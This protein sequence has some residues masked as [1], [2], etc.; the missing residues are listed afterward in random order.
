MVNM[1][2][3]FALLFQLIHICLIDCKRCAYMTACVAMQLQS[4][5]C[6]LSY[7]FA[8]VQKLELTDH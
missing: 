8:N 4:K 1:S 2:T 5:Q 3:P 6:I 7:T